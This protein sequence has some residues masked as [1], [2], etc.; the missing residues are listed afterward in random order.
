LS[1][2]QII[3]S[4]A[5]LRLGLAGGGTD[6]SPYSEDYGGAILNATV[7]LYAHTSIET[8]SQN[9]VIME[10]FDQGQKY[11]Y[12]TGESLEINGD[13]DLLKG[14]YNHIRKNYEVDIPGFKLTT[15][16]DAPK[17]SGM[18][19]SSTIT[20][21]ILGAF[22]EWLNLPLGKYDIARSAYEI[23][24]IELGMAGGKQDQYAATFG[25]FNFMEFYADEK[26][27]VNHL[28]IKQDYL[29]EL[30]LNFLLYYTG[31]SRLS[32]KIIQEQVHSLFQKERN[33]F[34]RSCS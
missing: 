29:K 9:Q 28:S 20:V 33:G 22:V 32:T 34:D 12:P 8:I 13:L 27:I 7:D 14:V 4:Q 16:A 5:P 10:S 18:G 11:V 26:V 2:H 25:G 23:E 1:N 19:A 15:F 17:G 31:T 24:R 3:R 21:S 6:V 30:N